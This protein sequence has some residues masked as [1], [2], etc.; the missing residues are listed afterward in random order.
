M[1][2]VALKIVRAATVPFTALLI[3]AGLVLGGFWLWGILTEYI[4]PKTATQRKDFVNVFVIIV[5]SVVGFLTALAAVG[6]FFV[7]S[8]NLRQQREL[9]ERRAQADALQSYFNYIGNLLTEHDL[10]NLE[11]RAK[12]L[13]NLAEEGGEIPEGILGTPPLVQLAIAQTLTVLGRL[14]GANKGHVVR[15][16]YSMGLLRST[17]EHQTTVSLIGADLTEAD[18]VG[19]ELHGALLTGA[20]LSRAD[21]RGANLHGADLQDTILHAADLS[22]E[23]FVPPEINPETSRPFNPTKNQTNLVGANLTS[24]NLSSADLRG[25]YIWDTTCNLTNFTR[26][27]GVSK[28]QLEETALA[29]AYATMPDGSCYGEDERPPGYTLNARS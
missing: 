8:E 24:A 20:D 16:L 13:A 5:A 17:G 6:N 26:A 2:Y 18:L 7:S 3:I 15:F 9:E 22:S 29:L 1:I 28:E 21:L 19:A 25:V 23:P 4:D 12:K 11:K 27:K 14:D 10:A